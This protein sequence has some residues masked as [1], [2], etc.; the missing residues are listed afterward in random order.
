MTDGN[1]ERS[2]VE[3]VSRGTKRAAF[4]VRQITTARPRRVGV[5]RP[6]KLSPDSWLK[7]TRVA[8]R[9]VFRSF[10]ASCDLARQVTLDQF[11]ERTRKS[12]GPIRILLGRCGWD[13][14]PLVQG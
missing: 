4:I 7:L 8:V 13:I 6:P 2:G 11:L 5:A 10:Q 12:H 14:R 9:R 3:S 1:G